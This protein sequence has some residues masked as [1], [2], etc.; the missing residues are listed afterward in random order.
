MNALSV[1]HLSH[2]FGSRRVLDDVSFSV[3]EGGMCILLGRN[4]AGKTTLFSLITGLY[5]ARAGSV[6][7]FGHAMNANPST[8][9]AEMGVVFQQPT[10][11]LDLTAGENLRYHAAL[12][13]LP[14]A[15]S[16]ER[17]VEEL[18][19]LEVADRIGD[20]ARALSGGQRRRV[21]I[22]RALM[23]RPRLLL[24]DEPTTGLDVPGRGALERHVRDL[25]RDR[26]IAVLWATHFLEEV[27]SADRV[28]VLHEGRVRWGGRADRLAAAV[29]VANTAEAFASLTG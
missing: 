14:K 22:A 15:L 7:V 8:A 18:R 26:G 20:P 25:C 12:H 3:P 9:L 28:V 5:H 21:E 23:H 10:L 17:S 29:G 11:D 27:S 19:R 16:K 13:G 4:G 1:D 2:S 6:L 24:L